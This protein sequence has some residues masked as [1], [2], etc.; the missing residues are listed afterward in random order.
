MGPRTIGRSPIVRA[1]PCAEL[2]NMM[3][4]NAPHYLKQRALPSAPDVMKPLTLGAAQC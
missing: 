1:Q 2:Y 3:P 4:R